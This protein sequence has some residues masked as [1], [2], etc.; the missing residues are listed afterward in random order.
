MA[1]SIG[2]RLAV[3]FLL[4]CSFAP[5]SA[6]QTVQ[7]GAKAGFNASAVE[8][9][10][11]YY[12]WVLCCL[13]ANPDAR[14]TSTV[15]G[16]FTAG[17]FVT[18]PT[19]GRIA[20]QGELSFSRR[21]HGVDLAP[22]ES[23]QIT[24]RRDDVET[25]ALAR[26]QFPLGRMNQIFVG[27]GPVFSF[28]VGEGAASSDRTLR[29]GDPE[30]TVYVVQLLPY[31]APELLRTSRA[32]IA[33]VGGWE[34]R[35]VVLE[36]RFTQ[37]LQSLFKDREGIVAGLVEVGGHEPTLQRLVSEFGPF[38]ESAK[39]RDFAVLIGIRF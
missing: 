19:R 10:V 38:L 26:L 7:W 13:P 24:F 11:E 4:L 25:A 6:A 16:G 8:Q 23:I 3:A 27:A 37:G 22:Y 15:S 12:D 20:L 30:T 1:F 36:A 17:G 2:R 34:Y 32:S 39:M 31:A 28:K 21:R 29:R 14:V 35:R 33:F 5:A 18:W 9:I